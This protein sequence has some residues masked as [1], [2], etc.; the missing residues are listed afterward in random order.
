M[1]IALVVALLCSLAPATSAQ[2]QPQTQSRLVNGIVAIVN[3]AIITR[4]DMED[5][6][7]PVMD[8]LIRQYGR[9]PEVLNQKVAEAERDALDQLIERKLILHD[10][11]SAGYNL[12]ESVIEDSIQDRIR[13]RFGDRVRLTK[14]LQAQDTTYESFRQQIREQIIVDA[15]R[16]R[17]ISAALIISPF[18][19]ETYYNDH[20]D[21]FKQEESAK[22]RMIVLN[23]PPGAPEGTAQKLAKEILLKL[24]E[25]VSFDEMA[26]VYSEGSQPGESTWWE[27]RALRKE[28]A[29][30]AFGLKP[31]ERSGAIVT[32]DA[33]YLVQVEEVKPA[34]AK[35][36]AEVRDAIEKILLAEER[37][38]LQKKY[39]DRLKGKSFLRYF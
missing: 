20:K 4:Q 25:G 24:E 18:K 2:P 29:D 1:R 6:L 26:T 32:P 15:L 9:Q 13:E 11:K 34:G 8:L 38:R 37:A 10:F 23:Q 19:I 33:C 7:V 39:V 22:L 17:H 36:L 30:V 14:T 12:P 31:G 16:A 27:R 28:L 21:E 35:P 5:L 3:D